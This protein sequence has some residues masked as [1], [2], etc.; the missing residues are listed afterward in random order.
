MVKNK[1]QIYRMYIYIYT[2]K[3]E[4]LKAERSLRVFISF[5]FSKIKLINPWYGN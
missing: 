2:K 3:I 4:N 5:Y 1:K